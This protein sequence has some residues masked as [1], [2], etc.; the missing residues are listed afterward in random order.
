MSKTKDLTAL[1]LILLAKGGYH[2]YL[3]FPK[4]K[5]NVMRDTGIQIHVDENGVHCLTDEDVVQFLK[6]ELGENFKVFSFWT[7]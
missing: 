1:R 3:D 4:G 7:T 2:V 6:E 5:E